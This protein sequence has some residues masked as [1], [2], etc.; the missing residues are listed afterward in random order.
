M[1]LE[2]IGQ[3]ADLGW[4]EGDLPLD[5]TERGGIRADTMTGATSHP[6]IFVAGDLLTG[7]ATVI[8]AIATGMRA[9]WALDRAVRGEGA[10]PLVSRKL[11]AETVPTPSRYVPSAPAPLGRTRGP[12]R[13]GKPAKGDFAPV[14]EGLLENQA[15]AEATRCFACGLCGRCTNCID[16]FGCPAFVRDGSRIFI[17]EE[18]CIGCG[19]CA[20]L[21]ANAA[22][23]PVG[24]PE[25]G[26]P[27]GDSSKRGI[28]S[29]VPAA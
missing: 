22:I 8:Q 19:V 26:A 18:L 9:A 17:D 11:A 2:A 21:C 16:N 5:R 23:V 25:T 28:P 10:A 24:S 13:T 29:Q 15:R 7:P 14:E 4:L 27:A 1:V 6:R 20:Q 12:A 3:E